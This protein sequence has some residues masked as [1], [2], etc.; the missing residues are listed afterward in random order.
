MSAILQT[1]HRELRERYGEELM[2]TLDEMH[3]FAR[4]IIEDCSPGKDGPDSKY[5]QFISALIEDMGSMG[6]SIDEKEVREKLPP[7]KFFEFMKSFALGV[8]YVAHKIKEE[9]EV[10]DYRFAHEI[11]LGGKRVSNFVAFTNITKN[12]ITIRPALVLGAVSSPD[13]FKEELGYENT[14]LSPQEVF[15][16]LGVEEM[17]HIFQ[18][19]HGQRPTYDI[20]NLDKRAYDADPTEQIAREV[21]RIAIDELKLG[22]AQCG[23]SR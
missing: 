2:G 19:Q 17:L 12:E 20:T 14:D 8:Q 10:N 1:V 23:V 16:L 6:F 18:G 22:A 5:S 7:A 9:A 4:Q 21:E 15:T 3:P 11:T 13:A